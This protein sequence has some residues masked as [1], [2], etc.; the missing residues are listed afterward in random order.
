LFLAQSALAAAMKE[1]NF[2]ALISAIRH[3]ASVNMA[4]N[5]GWT[6]LLEVCAKM[7]DGHLVK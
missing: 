4:N 5:E 1:S 3:G 2:D 7:N 6:P